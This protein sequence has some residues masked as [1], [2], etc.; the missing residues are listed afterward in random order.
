MKIKTYAQY[1]AALAKIKAIIGNEMDHTTINRLKSLSISDEQKLRQIGSALNEVCD[2][3]IAEMKSAHLALRL[4][5]KTIKPTKSK[6]QLKT[7]SK[8]VND[9]KKQL[10]TT[11]KAERDNHLR[12]KAL[13]S[14]DAAVAID[15]SLQLKVI[16]RARAVGGLFAD[17]NIEVVDSLIVKAN[18]VALTAAQVA[19]YTE[20]DGSVAFVRGQ[21]GL[22]TMVQPTVYT[23]KNEFKDYISKEV[24]N[25][26]HVDVEG[27]LLNQMS[28]SFNNE[29]AIQFVAGDETTNKEFM[30]IF[31]NRFHTTNSFV[32]D[33]S[34]DIETLGA[35]D[36][37]VNGSLGGA[38]P[39]VAGNAVDNIRDFIDTLPT[40][41]RDGAKLYMH[42]SV[43]SHIRKLKTLEGASLVVNGKIDDF[44][45]VL[46]DMMP[47]YDEVAAVAEPLILFG[48]V[49][50]AFAVKSHASE[51]DINPY[52]IDGAV[53]YEE[54]QRM[55]S[56]IKDNN[57]LRIFFAGTKAP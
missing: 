49:N 32:A 24:I 18:P 52:K 15:K 43:L 16:E 51:L 40:E 3:D 17:V 50:E 46:D 42:K 14:S 1:Q 47:A 11:T 8:K 54:V 4:K 31:G 30:G 25:D 36:S 34:R 37:K 19:A 26:V 53:A 12:G 21:T 10:K 6:S 7:K 44:D 33:S 41:H 45:V 39:S 27:W 13:L 56:F 28:R 29:F 57:A 38:D 35:F 2:S 9:V 48:K 23:G 55:S 5:A 22:G 20:S